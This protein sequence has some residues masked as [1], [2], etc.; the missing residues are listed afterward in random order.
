HSAGTT[1]NI[2]DFSL[3]ATQ[4][5]RRLS[6]VRQR[7]EPHRP[8]GRCLLISIDLRKKRARLQRA[9][10]TVQPGERRGALL[11]EPQ[12]RLTDKADLSSPSNACLSWCPRP[13][14]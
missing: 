3:T 8:P 10:S 2:C 1:T 6:G 12:R 11:I 7:S 14:R 5:T 13:A 4:D 9:V